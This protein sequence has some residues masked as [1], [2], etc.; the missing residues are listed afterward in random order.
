MNELIHAETKTPTNRSYLP[1]IKTT[2]VW[3]D[4]LTAGPGRDTR[5]YSGGLKFPLGLWKEAETKSFV[6]KVGNTTDTGSQGRI[7]APRGA[8]RLNQTLSSNAR[9]E[10]D[11]G[12]A[13]PKRL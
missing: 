2:P 7:Y 5:T 1:S 10:L 8:R 11:A 6:Y 12:A 4:S 3:A 13:H 9:V